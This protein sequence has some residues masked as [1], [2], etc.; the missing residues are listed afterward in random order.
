MNTVCPSPGVHHLTSVRLLRFRTEGAKQGIMHAQAV[1]GGSQI[2]SK[3]ATCSCSAGSTSGL[4]LH[5]YNSASGTSSEHA[6]K[7]PRRCT[8]RMHHNPLRWSRFQSGLSST[9]AAE[10]HTVASPPMQKRQKRKNEKD[11]LLL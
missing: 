5:M 3:V 7:Q 8:R 1:M 11:P 6:D 4:A 2:Y 9:D 10:R